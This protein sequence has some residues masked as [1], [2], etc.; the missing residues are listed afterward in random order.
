MRLIDRSIIFNILFLGR[1]SANQPQYALVRFQGSARFISD[2]VNQLHEQYRIPVQRRPKSAIRSASRTPC[3]SGLTCDGHKRLSCVIMAECFDCKF[4]THGVSSTHTTA[5]WRKPITVSSTCRLTT[6]GRDTYRT[7]QKC[8]LSK[9]NSST[10]TKRTPAG[11]ITSQWLIFSSETSLVFV[12]N[13]GKGAVLVLMGA[14][15][16]VGGYTAMI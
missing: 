11:P 8:R 13:N 5:H 16:S 4:S 15:V 2:R 1:F 12:I 3:K 7:F 9:R 6:T 14:G 10:R